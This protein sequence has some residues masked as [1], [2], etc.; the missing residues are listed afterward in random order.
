MPGLQ[1]DGD[2]VVL[3][4]ISA[5]HGVRRR[6]AGRHGRSFRRKKTLAGP[7]GLLLAAVALASCTDSPPPSTSSKTVSPPASSPSA[8]AASASSGAAA[9]DA[10][11]VESA[12]RAFWPVVATFGERP[13]SQWRTVLGQV[14]VDPQLSFAIAATRQQYRNGI[15]VYGVASPRKPEVAGGSG[16]GR[17]TIRDCAD[18]SRTGQAD[19]RT[20]KPRT[21][22]VARTPLSAVLLKGADGRWRVSQVTFLGGRC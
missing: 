1:A 8:P 3:V 16:S 18:F 19:A 17:V 11:A 2:R 12:Y 15:T 4:A 13:E 6:P 14:A 5:Q 20:K 21:V 9:P 22:G 7:A 10:A